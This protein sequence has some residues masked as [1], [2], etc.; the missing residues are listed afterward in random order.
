MTV[1]QAVRRA[2]DALVPGE[3]VQMHVG[4]LDGQ[5]PV[6]DAQA[7]PQIIDAVRTRG[8]RIRSHHDPME[9][10]GRGVTGKPLVVMRTPN[11]RIDLL[12]MSRG[13]VPVRHSC[14]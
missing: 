12:S 5:D 7:L 9:F 6:L 8:Y 2:L 3:I 10:A 11:L 4:S 13:A 14:V 1:Q